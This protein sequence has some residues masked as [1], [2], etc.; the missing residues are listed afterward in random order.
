MRQLLCGVSVLALIATAAMAAAP[1][2]SVISTG[3]RITPTAANGSVFAPLN[4][5]IASEPNYTVGQA[6]TTAVSPDGRT[7]LVL[8]SGFNLNATPTGAVDPLTST[9]FVFV[10]DI[11]GA[12]PVQMQALPVP[13]AFS[14]VAWA[15]NGQSFYVGGGKDDVVHVF[16]KGADGFAETGKPI[17][18]NDTAFGVPQ[19]AGLGLFSIPG[20]GAAVSPLNGGMAVTADGSTLIVAELENDQLNYVNLAT[21]AVTKQQLRPGKLDAT[22]TGIPG[23]EFPYWVAVTANNTIY[24]SSE[25]DR[26]IDVVSMA[27]GTVTARIKVAGNPNRMVLNKAQTKLFV[28]ADNSDMLYVI[29]TASNTIVGQVR[30]TAPLGYVTQGPTNGASPNSVTLSP[31][32]KTAYV[33]NA[34]LNA[35]AVI[36]VSAAAPVVTGLIPTGWEPTS[37]STNADGSQL[38]IIN[39]QSPTGP[40]PLY[41]K[42]AANQYDWQL[43]KAGFLTLPTP[44]A[45][46]LIGLTSIVAGNN[47]FN[48]PFT[49]ADAETMSYLRSHIQHVIYIVKENRTY[50]QILGDLGRGNGDRKLTMYGAAL[51]PNFHALAT[52]FVDLDNY[53]DPSLSSMDGWQFST[54]GR[55]Q[56]LNKKV[57]AVNY[58][59]GGGSYD[60]EGL[61]RDINVGVGTASQRVAEAPIYGVEAAKDPDLLPGTA[62]EVAPDSASGEQGSG[63]IWSAAMRAKLSVRNYGFMLD[64][65]P[66][67]VPPSLGQV[68]VLRD[69]FATRTVVA[70]PA[71]STLVGRTDLYFRGFDNNLPDFYRYREWA[72]EFDGF[73]RVGRMPS[74]ETVRFMHDHTGSFSTAIDGVNTPELQQADNDYAVGLLIDKVAHSPYANSTLVFV[75]EDDSQDGPDHVDTH[76]STAYVVGPYV[77]QG[78]VVN[79]RYSTVSML[80]TMGEILGLEKLDLQVASVAPMTDIFDLTKS[81]WSYSAV[82]ALSLLTNTQLPILNKDQLLKHANLEGAPALRHDAIWWADKTKQFRF[83]REDLNDENAYNHVLWEGTM[84]DQPYPGR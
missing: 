64:L 46:D 76:R 77:K 23:G 4:P 25:R 9:E 74:F 61:S 52:Q 34:G 19:P 42:P 13:N 39:A 45:A 29:D 57:N 62:N 18:L 47:H 32:E 14:G 6:E 63:F 70:F 50:D 60:S 1:A 12:A 3:Q 54:A 28:T 79:T 44:S 24:V 37:V 36:D 65:V 33:T 80:R 48:R 38:Y 55:V 20:L 68:P 11:S 26:E 27:A 7:M 43:S 73:V 72:R 22:K 10:F 81:S 21:G 15:P 35:V 69:P 17:A 16:A 8:T 30:T 2:G 58:G 5:H 41:P 40:N 83:D 78:A 75:T 31:D 82:P 59:K 56:D 51:T 66:Y 67:S 71:T 49:A 84:G 53:Y